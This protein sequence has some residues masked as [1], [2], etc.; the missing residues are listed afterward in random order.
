MRHRAPDGDS[1]ADVRR[2]AMAALYDSAEVKIREGG[3]E[4]RWGCALIAHEV[5]GW[6]ANCPR[7]ILAVEVGAWRLVAA[8]HPAP[9][10]EWARAV[11]A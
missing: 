8:G 1:A 5:L 7:I 11:S 4:P 10:V 2:E 6:C 3:L 9:D